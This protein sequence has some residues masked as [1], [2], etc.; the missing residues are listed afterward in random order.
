MI[1]GTNAGWCFWFGS[2]QFDFILIKG[3]S[4]HKIFY[5]DIQT[6]FPF[7]EVG[8]GNSCSSSIFHEVQLTFFLLSIFCSVSVSMSLMNIYWMPKE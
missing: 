2:V 3:T 5:L 4:A 7:G 8:M 1:K 6:M